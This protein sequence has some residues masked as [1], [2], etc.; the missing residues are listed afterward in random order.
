MRTRTRPV[1]WLGPL[2]H[3]WPCVTALACALA[4]PSLADAAP[5]GKKGAASKDDA[6]EPAAKADDEADAESDDEQSG[7]GGAEA[8]VGTSGA[9]ASAGAAGKKGAPMKG[10]FGFGAMRTVSG[11]NALYGRYYLGNRFTLGLGA[12]V[13]TF[14][15]R[16]TDDNGEFSRKRTVGAFAVGPEAFFWPVQGKRDQQVHADFGIGVRALTYVGFLGLT[17]QERSETLDTPVEIDVEIPAKILLFIGP[18][19]SVNPEFGF[20]VRII[21]GSREPDGNGDSDQNPGTGIGSRLGTND[22]PG[23]GLELGNHAGFFMGIGVGYWFG[24]L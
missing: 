22:G 13:A 15:H 21:P 17:E 5:K 9:T 23:L 14:T 18:R 7:T 1:S 3:G 2:S 4:V 11:L 24:K 8:S 12:G 20:V 6:A 19:V 10:R 16:D